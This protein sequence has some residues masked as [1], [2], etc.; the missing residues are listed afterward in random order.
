LALKKIDDAL[1]T[2]ETGLDYIFE[3]NELAAKYYLLMANIYK[4]KNNIKK[5][6]TFSSKAEEI[7]LKQ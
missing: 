4:I 1:V 7:Q 3:D 2:L 6:Q 5:A